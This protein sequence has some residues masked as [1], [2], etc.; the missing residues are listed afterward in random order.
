MIDNQHPVVDD[1]P[2]PSGSLKSRYIRVSIKQTIQH[3][4][5]STS[6]LHV[7]VC[8]C[9]CVCVMHIAGST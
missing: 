1:P 8:V 2:G 9:V 7:C 3:V 5:L 4:S 6:A